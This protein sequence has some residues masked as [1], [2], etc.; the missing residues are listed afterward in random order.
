M[1]SKLL[2]MDFQGLQLMVC[3]NI[4]PMLMYSIVSSAELQ[5]DIQTAIPNIVKFLEDSDSHV[6]QAALYGLS[7]LATHGMCHCSSNADVLNWVFS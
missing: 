3:I 4:P 6:Q 2:A 1:F 5:K 7:H